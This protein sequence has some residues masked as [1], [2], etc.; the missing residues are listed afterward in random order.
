MLEKLPEFGKAGSSIAFNGWELFVSPELEVD[1]RNIGIQ[2]RLMNWSSENPLFRY[3]PNAF[4]LYL[5][6]GTVFPQNTQACQ[7]GDLFQ[8]RQI[9]INSQDKLDIKSEEYWCNEETNIPTFL[10]TIPVKTERL[11]LNLIQ[12]GVFTDLVTVFDL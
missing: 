12:L 4:V 6:D 1:S 5:E 8:S 9:G 2:L 3:Q 10:G 11:Y 7:P